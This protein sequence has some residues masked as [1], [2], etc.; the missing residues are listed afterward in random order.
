MPDNTDIDKPLNYTDYY[1]L[2]ALLRRK[3]LHN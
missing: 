3:G 2:E 1:Y